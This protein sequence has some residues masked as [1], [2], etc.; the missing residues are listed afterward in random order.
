MFRAGTRPRSFASAHNE[1]LIFRGERDTSYYVPSRRVEFPRASIAKLLRSRTRGVGLIPRFCAR[2]RRCRDLPSR[3][4]PFCVLTLVCAL[5]DSTCGTRPNTCGN[6]ENDRSWRA[7]S[8]LS[9]FRKHVRTRAYCSVD[10]T[11][12][13]QVIETSVILARAR[14]QLV[15]RR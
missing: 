4:F 14:F 5:P 2:L 1:R 10:V 6:A 8:T 15:S 3:Y 12:L 13:I 9:F 7:P 11:R